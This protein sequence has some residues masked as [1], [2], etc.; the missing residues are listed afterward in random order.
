MPW[1]GIFARITRE[2]KQLFPNESVL[3]V[4]RLVRG[5]NA[6]DRAKGAVTIESGSSAALLR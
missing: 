4:L 2:R 1:H 5:C 6:R 3:R